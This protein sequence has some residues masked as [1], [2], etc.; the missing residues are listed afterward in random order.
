MCDHKVNFKAYLIFYI[1]LCVQK[2]VQF[3]STSYHDKTKCFRLNCIL[4]LMMKMNI[5]QFLF[6][7]QRIRA[8]GPLKTKCR[9]IPGGLI[10]KVLVFSKMKIH[11]FKVS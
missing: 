1:L 6:H 8:E 2:S 11:Y 5:K 7:S 4:L 10:D 9:L 3:L